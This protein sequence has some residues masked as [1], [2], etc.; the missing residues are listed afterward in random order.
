[1]YREHRQRI[2]RSIA[3]GGRAGGLRGSD[4]DDSIMHRTATASD[5]GNLVPLPPGE[6]IAENPGASVNRPGSQQVTISPP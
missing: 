1:M 5:T 2:S 3:D 4:L 6:S